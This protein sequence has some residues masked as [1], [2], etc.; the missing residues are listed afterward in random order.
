LPPEVF[1]SAWPPSEKGGY[2]LSPST[3]VALHTNAAP[4][5]EYLRAISP[6]MLIYMKEFSLIQKAE[7]VR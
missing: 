7:A 5:T 6:K 1:Q 2:V 4:H 3:E